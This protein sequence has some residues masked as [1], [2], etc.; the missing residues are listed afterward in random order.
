MLG[1]NGNAAG[2]IG[3]LVKAASLLKTLEDG[4]ADKGPGAEQLLRSRAYLAG[5]IGHAREMSTDKAAARV[6]LGE[7]VD[8]WDRLGKMRP[9]SEEYQQ[10]QKWCR[11][12][13]ER[14]ESGIKVVQ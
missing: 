11:E 8:L 7:A 10:A 2:E 6:S 14:L 3:L 9:R 13:L 12:R 4:A 1:I 5:D